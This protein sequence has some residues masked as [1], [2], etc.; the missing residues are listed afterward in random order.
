MASEGA[1]CALR[2]ASLLDVTEQSHAAQDPV[3]RVLSGL[4]RHRG[5][6]GQVGSARL[7]VDGAD[8][9]TGVDH[10]GVLGVD[11]D[12]GHDLEEDLVLGLDQ[13]AAA[14]VPAG[15]LQEQ[16]VDVDALG[17]RV[18]D[19]ILHVLRHV[20]LHDNDVQGPALVSAGHFLKRKERGNVHCL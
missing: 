1:L 14:P 7:L 18:V 9:E 16:A 19:V 5:D 6:V 8:I 11:V 17:R 15:P 13:L 3:V 12:D 20:V 10:H 4:Q 2:A